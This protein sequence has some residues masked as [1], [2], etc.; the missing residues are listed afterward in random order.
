MRH[1]AKLLL[2]ITALAV[3]CSHS[4]PTMTVTPVGV[5]ESAPATVTATTTA[6]Q[7]QTTTRT[8]G[9]PGTSTDFHNAV[10]RAHAAFK[11]LRE[12]KNPDYSP[13]LAKVDPNLFGVVIVTT[14]GEVYEV[15]DSGHL[16][17]IQ[18]V[19]KV[20]TLGRVL[21]SLG[22]DAVEKRIGVDAT[23]QPFNSI[24]AMELDD[25][26][27]AGN[28]FVNPG[29]IGVVGLVPGATAGIRWASIMSNLEAFAG[30]KLGVDAQVYKSE[31]E[32]NTRNR[33]IAWLLKSYGVIPGDP[34]EALDLFTRQCSVVVNARDLAV[35][36]ATLANGGKNPVTGRQGV[37]AES[38]G[39][40]LSE[41][42][43]TGLY[44]TTGA[45]SFD[46][47][48]PAKSGVGGGI[49]AVVPGRYAIGT[50]S[51]PLDVA[52]NSVRGQRAIASIV[53]DLGGNVFLAAAPKHGEP[54]SAR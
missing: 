27:H 46:V 16:F 22:K 29:A 38:A 36:G 32:T 26:H 15:G 1:S 54:T 9:V 47:G 7:T 12:G 19:A 33:G 48:V 41:M 51:T 39:H 4:A 23:G 3:A 42:L 45:W 24:L 14:Q 37:S 8:G 18:S 13:V 30:R 17:S 49:V 25:A 5:S 34:M 43:T 28:P 10:Q 44:E 52:G 40:L 31:S 21:E 35:M 53:K 11:P 2:P 50:F 20:F 6:A